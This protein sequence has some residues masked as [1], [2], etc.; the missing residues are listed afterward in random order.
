MLTEQTTRRGRH[1]SMNATSTT[2]WFLIE[3]AI[4]AVWLFIVLTS[5]IE[6]TAAIVMLMVMN[7]VPL[8]KLCET[9]DRRF[10]KDC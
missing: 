10:R 5:G 1:K 8:M 3:A 9:L 2:K 7:I 6:T 4:I